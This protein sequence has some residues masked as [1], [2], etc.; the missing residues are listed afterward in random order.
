MVSKTRVVRKI[1]LLE[2][3]LGNFKRPWTLVLL[4]INLGSCYGLS[5]P[6]HPKFKLLPLPHGG[7]SMHAMACHTSHLFWPMYG[8]YLG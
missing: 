2:I 6:I 1:N 8:I 3:I 7:L 5:Y 4:G